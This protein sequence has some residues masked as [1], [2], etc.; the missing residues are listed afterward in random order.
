MA[1]LEELMRAQE[2][3]EQAVDETLRPLLKGR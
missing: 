1:S 3:S 2:E